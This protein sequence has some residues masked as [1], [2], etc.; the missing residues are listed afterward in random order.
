ML[1][2]HKQIDSRTFKF[3]KDTMFH[4]FQHAKIPVFK[5]CGRCKCFREMF[6]ISLL[7]IHPGNK[8]ITII[9]MTVK[10]HYTVNTVNSH[11]SLCCCGFIKECCYF[12][13]FV[14]SPQMR[15][16]YSG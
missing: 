11:V 4:R 10:R 9:A 2:K 12:L 7:L 1:M 16:A 3:R 15:I 13:I 5:S 6:L 8:T 14:T